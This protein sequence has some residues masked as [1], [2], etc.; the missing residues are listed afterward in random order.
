MMCNYLQTSDKELVKKFVD[1]MPEDYVFE[2]TVHGEQKKLKSARAHIY[3]NEELV[4]ELDFVNKKYQKL[5]IDNIYSEFYLTDAEAFALNMY[6]H[7]GALDPVVPHWWPYAE[8]NIARHN[9]PLK[10]LKEAQKNN[11]KIVITFD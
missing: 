1:C 4:Y 6:L 11:S 5:R 9:D 10:A 3:I 8:R 2:V 7:N